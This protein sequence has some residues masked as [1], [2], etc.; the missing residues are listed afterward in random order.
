MQFQFD[1]YDIKVNGSQ[2]DGC[3]LD[4]YMSLDVWSQIYAKLETI[5]DEYGKSIDKRPKDDTIQ[6]RR[7]QLEL[8]IVWRTMQ[9]FYKEVVRLEKTNVALCQF[10]MVVKVNTVSVIDKYKRQHSQEKL[11]QKSQTQRKL[12]SSDAT[13]SSNGSSSNDQEEEYVPSS[14]NN[15]SNNLDYTP[16]TLTNSTEKKS[17]AN[18]NTDEYTPITQIADDDI[19]TYTPTKIEQHKNAQLKYKSSTT[20]DVNRNTCPDKKTRT[21]DLFGDSDE[22][23]I[24]IK[25]NFN[26]RSKS[27]AQTPSKS[28]VKTQ[29]SMDSWITTR[30]SKTQN[31]ASNVDT[32]KKRK[33]DEQAA[34]ESSHTKHSNAPSAKDE[35]RKKLRA[36][37]K[38]WEEVEKEKQIVLDDI[39]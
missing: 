39:L 11:S 17:K 12:D 21:D 24:P 7:A 1:S 22:S 27:V 15:I 2:I 28:A 26:L 8:K 18:S 31:P 33:L 16:T 4:K 29:K 10:V 3:S 37:A 30:S 25:S 23:D 13:R 34:I 20:I 35:E 19:V 32:T 38:E 9:P 36:L 6:M 14:R 5:V